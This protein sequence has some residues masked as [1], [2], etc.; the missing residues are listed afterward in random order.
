MNAV[1]RKLCLS[2]AWRPLKLSGDPDHVW[3]KDF[4]IASHRKYALSVLL[5]NDNFYHYIA[6]L[7]MIIIIIIAITIIFSY[8]HYHYHAYYHYYYHCHTYYHYY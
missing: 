7:I 3:I 6:I 4:F 2:P 8:H 1:L 5:I